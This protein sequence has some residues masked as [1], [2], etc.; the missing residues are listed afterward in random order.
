MKKNFLEVHI[1]FLNIQYNLRAVIRLL[2]IFYQS[3]F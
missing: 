3:F 1:L 2:A